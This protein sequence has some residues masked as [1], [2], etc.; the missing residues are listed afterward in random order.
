[1]WHHLPLFF[2]LPNQQGDLKFQSS[3]LFFG[4]GFFNSQ[5]SFDRNWVTA[6]VSR[7][8][9][10]V[11]MLWLLALIRS[12]WLGGH[13]SPGGCFCESNRTI[14]C[15]SVR[16]SNQFLREI[17]QRLGLRRTIMV[18]SGC[19]TGSRK[20]YS[21]PACVSWQYQHHLTQ[22]DSWN[23]YGKEKKTFTGKLDRKNVLKAFAAFRW[24]C[25]LADRKSLQSLADV[26]LMWAFIQVR[27]FGR[28]CA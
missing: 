8:L 26:Q 9:I 22:D 19:L 7:S 2:I 18:L 25:S 1:M 14:I 21:H 13:T 20:G 12:N 6:T 10:W 27:S 28:F 4:K 16:M 15:F 3:D 11:R 17:K 24:C 5:G 23:C